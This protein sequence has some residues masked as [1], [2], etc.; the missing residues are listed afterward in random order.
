MLQTYLPQSAALMADS[1]MQRYG[2]LTSRWSYD[3]GVTWRGM[4]A[5]HAL[6]GEQKYFD[7]IKDAMDT[8]VTDETGSIRD[9]SFDALNLDYICNGRQ[10]LYLYRHTGEEKYRR[11]ADTLREQ[12][13]HQPRT[14]DGGFW[15]KKCYPYQMWLDG[16]HMSAPFY[17]EYCLLAGDDQGVQDAAKQLMLAYEHTLNPDTGLNHHAWDESRGQQWSDPET[18]R[19]A[20]CWGRAVGWYMLGLADVL[21]LLPQTHPCFAPLQDIFRK[22]TGRMLEC[23]VDGVWTQVIDCSDR[24]GNYLESSGS[25][26]MVAAML[27]MARLGYI[28]PEMGAAAQESFRAIQR[29]FVGQM[30]NGS[31]FLAKTCGGAGL[32]GFPHSYRDGS[33]DYYISEAV[34]SYDLKGTGAYIQAACEMERSQNNA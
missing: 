15:H 12:L 7:Y 4:E 28:A 9:Y 3:Y 19:A 34:V 30:V 21:E 2:L 6:T 25:C 13:R 33:F 24:P 11:A 29:E 31:L 27:K 16:L 32:G 10:L 26:L 18:G 1:L 22:M 14:S 8:F 23:R 5:L 17:V 20:H